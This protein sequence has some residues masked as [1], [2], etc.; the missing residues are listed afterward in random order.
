MLRKCLLPQV[1][2]VVL[3]AALVE[4]VAVSHDTSYGRDPLVALVAVVHWNLLQLK[5]KLNLTYPLAILTS[6]C[7]CVRK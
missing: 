4:Y 6:A 3:D 7:V 1:A 5:F 2:F